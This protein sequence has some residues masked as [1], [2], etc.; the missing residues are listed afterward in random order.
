MVSSVSR[1]KSGRKG[2]LRG[3]VEEQQRPGERFAG[4]VVSGPS[5]SYK[6]PVAVARANWFAVLKE[7]EASSAIQHFRSFSMKASLVKVYPGLLERC[8]RESLISTSLSSQY[9]APFIDSI[10][11]KKRKE[12]RV[13]R[14]YPFYRTQGNW[15]LYQAFACTHR[16]TI[17]DARPSGPSSSLK[18]KLALGLEGDVREHEGA[19]GSAGGGVGSDSD[20]RQLGHQVLLRLGGEDGEDSEEIEGVDIDLR[21]ASSDCDRRS[22]LVT[23]VTTGQAGT[24]QSLDASPWARSMSDFPGDGTCAAPSV[25]PHILIRE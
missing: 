1:S 15:I 10:L 23:L 17:D 24:K 11:Q 8:M 19:G 2:V 22:R 16:N 25:G 9:V 6:E 4:A 12:I 18:L 13:S 21:V 20:S 5:S 14:N 3:D 7:L